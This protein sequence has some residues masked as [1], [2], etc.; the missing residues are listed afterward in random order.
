MPRVVD[1]GLRRIELT[2]AAARVIARSGVE[3][4][5]LREIAA[6]AGW[7]TG[8]LMHYFADKDELLLATFQASLAARRSRRVDR[9]DRSD[10]EELRA[11]LEGALP[12]DEERTRHWLVTLACCTQAPGN[13]ALAN[14]QRDAYREYRAHVAALVR[15]VGLASAD[16]ATRIAERLIAAVD[17]VAIQALFDPDS[18][19]AERQV[20]ALDVSLATAALQ[21]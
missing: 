14:A 11:A 16:D 17:G 10:A 19:P 4:A 8:V 6:E 20:A 1:A 21:H 12:V 2:D 7:T 9:A 5:T 13:E 15:S 3:A 18:W